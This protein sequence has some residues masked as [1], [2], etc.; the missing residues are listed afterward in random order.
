M[1]A[2]PV[3]MLL[4]AAQKI[5]MR[6]RLDAPLGLGAPFGRLIGYSAA[7]HRWAA[8]M[9]LELGLKVVG[10]FCSNAIIIVKAPQKE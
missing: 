6:F 8:R 3:V 1:V 7:D 5:W 4:L 10:Y 9:S 2:Q